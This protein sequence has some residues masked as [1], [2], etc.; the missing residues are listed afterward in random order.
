MRDGRTVASIDARKPQGKDAETTGSNTGQRESSNRS[1]RN[2]LGSSGCRVLFLDCSSREMDIYIYIYRLGVGWVVSKS[3]L[4]V[5]QLGR[6]TGNNA[7]IFY[8]EILKV[9]G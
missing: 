8:F 6:L 1:F 9:P 7:S 2:L 5:Y 4:F 3:F